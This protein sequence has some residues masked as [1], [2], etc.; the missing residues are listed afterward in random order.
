MRLLGGPDVGFQPMFCTPILCV[1]TNWRPPYF[2]DNRPSGCSTHLDDDG[3]MVRRLVI[4][5][6]ALVAIVG[7]IVVIRALLTKD[8]ELTA[9]DRETGMQ[10]WSTSLENSGAQWMWQEG[11]Q[12][13]VGVCHDGHFELLIDPTNGRIVGDRPGFA[14]GS[15]DTNAF[16]GAG[17]Q[18][19]APGPH[20][21]GL[22][23]AEELSY[24]D[25]AHLLVSAKGW[26]TEV[27]VSGPD[28]MPVLIRPDVVYFIEHAGECEGFD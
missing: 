28:W 8:S 7:A 14:F 17:V 6:A 4:G 16:A 2:V 9:V 27:D 13:V 18:T 15:E 12:L 20:G 22:P 1:L 5:V 26:R 11:H 10:L 19:R 21:F 3:A 24:D 23:V 25:A